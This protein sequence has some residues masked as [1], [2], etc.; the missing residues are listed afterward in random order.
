MAKLTCPA[1]MPEQ[2]RRYIAQLSLHA[3]RVELHRRH[4]KTVGL[5]PDL[6]ER[7]VSHLKRNLTCFAEVRSTQLGCTGNSA[8][9]PRRHSAPNITVPTHFPEDFRPFWE[10]PRGT[11]RGRDCTGSDHSGHPDEERRKVR[12]ETAPC[13]KY[14]ISGVLRGHVVWV[15][16]QEMMTFWDVAG[17]CGKANLSRSAPSFD[18]HATLPSSVLK[19][20]AMRQLLALEESEKHS[21]VRSEGTHMEHLQLT[22]IEAYYTSFVSK[23]LILSDEYGTRVSD[24]TLAWQLFCSRSHHFPHKFVAYCRYRATG[25]L[26]RSGIKYGVDWVLYPDTNRK[27][28]HSPYCVVLRFHEGKM[29]S[30]ID[31]TWI[32]LQNR[33]RLV[34]N[35]AKTL[36][37]ANIFVEDSK[38]L[39]SLE[40]A[41]QSVKITEMTVD[42]WLP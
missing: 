33:L 38:L 34:K 35:V 10:G 29:E 26:P 15:M 30:K 17:P 5:R 24:P 4:L 21:P 23:H 40:D 37:I 36:V 25:W 19:G 22:L 3:L 28:A 42:R 11:K 7:L 12:K 27:H 2:Q 1:G 18:S 9:R 8:R 6:E 32:R 16:G 41:F 13:S 39:A 20:R 14:Q 31:Q